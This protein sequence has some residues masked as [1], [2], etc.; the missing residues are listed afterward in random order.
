MYQSDI[1]VYV[2]ASVRTNE[3]IEN[4]QGFSNGM[5][6]DLVAKIL[7]GYLCH[8]FQST[9]TFPLKLSEIIS[10][11]KKNSRMF[12]HLLTLNL[13]TKSSN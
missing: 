13:K 7:D 6:F 5:K 10:D 11:E 8:R 4:R 2:H 3:C 12:G 1:R 9:A